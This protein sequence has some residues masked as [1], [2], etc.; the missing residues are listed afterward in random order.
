MKPKYIVYPGYCISKTDGD[1][2]WIS[3]DKLMRLYQ[4][5]PKECIVSVP[6]KESPQDLIPL[7]PKYDGNYTLPGPM[8]KIGPRTMGKS[9][10]EPV[11]PMS[12]PFIMED[13]E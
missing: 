6:W 5:D 8:G 9:I 11:R 3:A 4:V 1:K 10:A 2:H 13:K 12:F 7:R